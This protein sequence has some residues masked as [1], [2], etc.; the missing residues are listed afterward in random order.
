MRSKV[1]ETTHGSKL[2]VLGL[3]GVVI[4]SDEVESRLDL[5]AAS[6]EHVIS[7]DALT[8]HLITPERHRKW[9][10]MSR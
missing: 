5:I 10:M 9:K 2:G 3:V 7:A 8:A 6:P 1:T 4:Q